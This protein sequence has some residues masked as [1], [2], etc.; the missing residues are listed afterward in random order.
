MNIG[1]NVKILLRIS[2]PKDG[3]EAVWVKFQH[4]AHSCSHYFTFSCLSHFVSETVTSSFYQQI[5]YQ[6]SETFPG[7]F[8]GS[9]PRKHFHRPAMFPFRRP[10][11]ILV[12]ADALKG[13]LW[14]TTAS[15]RAHWLEADFIVG[16]EK[17]MSR[18]WTGGDVSPLFIQFSV[19]KCFFS[20]A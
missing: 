20:W 6:A 15:R 5:H 3:H 19:I 18:L 12:F 17:C 14:N 7:P 1:Y 2:L 4:A 8:T 9:S 13:F 16:E 10:I 11:L